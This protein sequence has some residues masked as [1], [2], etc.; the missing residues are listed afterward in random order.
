MTL[1]SLSHLT[2]FTV[3][4]VNPISGKIITQAHPSQMKPAAGN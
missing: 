4:L 2:P 3:R 1:S